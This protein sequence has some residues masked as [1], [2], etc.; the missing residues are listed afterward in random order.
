MIF[1]LKFLIQ[2]IRFESD[3][4]FELLFFLSF[5]PGNRDGM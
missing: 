5:N 2:I 1:S 4:I 3:L